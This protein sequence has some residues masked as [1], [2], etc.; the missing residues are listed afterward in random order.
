MRSSCSPPLFNLSG[1]K[2]SIN[3]K[4]FSGCQRALLQIVCNTSTRVH[5]RDSVHAFVQC[6]H[7]RMCARLHQRWCTLKTE[8]ALI[9]SMTPV[10]ED[11]LSSGTSS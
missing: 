10:S 3:H 7:L 2:W 6:L 4:K 5:V 1:C 8:A 11:R 9:V